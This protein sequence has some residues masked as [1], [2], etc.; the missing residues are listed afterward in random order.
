MIGYFAAHARL[1]VRIARGISHYRRAPGKPDR[2]V[3]PGRSCEPVMAG[4]AAIRSL[5][6]RL[7][8][9]CRGLATLSYARKKERHSDQDACDQNMADRFD[10]SMHVISYQPLR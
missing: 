4:K 1:P 7:L 9:L 6:Q 8:F 3:F 5:K 2:D 10:Q